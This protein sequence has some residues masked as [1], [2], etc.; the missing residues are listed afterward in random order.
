MLAVYQRTHKDV[1][2]NSQ[3]YS[4][5]GKSLPYGEGFEIVKCNNFTGHTTT[6]VLFVFKIKNT[7]GE[8]TYFSE[9]SFLE[10]HGRFGGQS[11]LSS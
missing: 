1:T 10:P 9:G 7:Y 3:L 11:P 6:T 4:Q 8:E 5:A 2:G